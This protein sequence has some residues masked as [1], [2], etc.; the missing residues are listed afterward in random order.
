MRSRAECF[1][2]TQPELQVFHKQLQKDRSE[3][4]KPPGSANHGLVVHI[5]SWWTQFC[6][7][8]AL[9]AKAPVA[10]YTLVQTPPD[11]SRQEREASSRL[12]RFYAWMLPH[13]QKRTKFTNEAVLDKFT[14]TFAGLLFMQFQREGT[15]A[16]IKEKYSYWKSVDEDQLRPRKTELRG[17]HKQ[18]RADAVTTDIHGMSVCKTVT[19]DYVSLILNTQHYQCRLQLHNHL[20]SQTMLAIILMC[21]N[22]GVAMAA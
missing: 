8:E 16:D 19:D 7:Y 5:L 15:P 11:D 6:N 2:V 4:F 10:N 12:Q 20:A 22:R 18:A 9:Q 3:G 13:V 14:S 21:G 1:Q 17:A